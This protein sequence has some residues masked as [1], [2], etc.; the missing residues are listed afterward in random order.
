[1]KNPA[2]KPTEL[3]AHR[4]LASANKHSRRWLVGVSFILALFLGSCEPSYAYDA[5]KITSYCACKK[6][7]GKS[8]GITA[9]GK[10]AKEN[11]TVACN[12]LPFGTRV[13]IA[14][15]LY[16]VEDRGARSLFGSKQNP[17][18]HI[19]IF[20]SN[21]NEARRFGVKYLNTEVL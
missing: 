4:P 14:G 8:D 1:M 11:H 15:K 17:I 10:H 21:H 5:W 20:Y 3:S 13:N 2:R 16:F 6:C 19:D 9:S 7:C 12:W 18:K